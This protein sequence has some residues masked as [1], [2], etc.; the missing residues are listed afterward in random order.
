MPATSNNYQLGVM[1]LDGD[2]Y[3]D[4]VTINDNIGLAERI[5]RN[6]GSGGFE[7]VTA[8]WWPREL[9]PGWDDNGVVFIDIDSDGDADLLIGSLDGPDR[10]LINDGSGRIIEMAA[11]IFDSTPTRGTL[12]M[13]IADLDG[14]GLPDIVESQGEVPGHE[15]NRVY[16]G[17]SLLAPDTAPP[18][19]A[20]DLS[21]GATSAVTV[22]ARVHDNRTPNMPHDWQAIVLRWTT[23]GQVVE[24]PLRWYGENLFRANVELPAD[25]TKVAVCATDAAGNEACAG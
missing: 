23:A 3:L 4:F 10:L 17:T 16:F 6:D 21:A 8:E 9:N 20:T 1:D 14:D 18:V 19:I 5:F 2:G 24:V 12:G 11:D 22:H 13:L 7:E 25:A 15:D